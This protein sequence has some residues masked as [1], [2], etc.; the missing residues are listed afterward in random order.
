MPGGDTCQANASGLQLDG[1][2]VPYDSEAQ[3]PCYY[4]DPAQAVFVGGQFNGA[5]WAIN[6]RLSDQHSEAAEGQLLLDFVQGRGVATSSFKEVVRGCLL[7]GLGF[8]LIRGNLPHFVSLKT[9]LACS[10]ISG[11]PQTPVRIW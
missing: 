9:R 1:R 5:G 10:S 7:G 4:F 6:R 2:L 3:E 11:P 8:L